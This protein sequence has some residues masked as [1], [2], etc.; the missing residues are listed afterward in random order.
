MF[1]DNLISAAEAENVCLLCVT[2]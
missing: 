1:L 2:Y